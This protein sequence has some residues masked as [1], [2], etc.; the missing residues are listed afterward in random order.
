MD[1][2]AKTFTYPNLPCMFEIEH[3][4]S[5]Q[6]LKRVPCVEESVTR[7]GVHKLILI[8]ALTKEN[9]YYFCYYQEWISCPFDRSSTCLSAS[10][11]VKELM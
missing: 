4:T 1:Y 7:F 10:R 9:N 8:F 5:I 3:T 6:T 2:K 11:K